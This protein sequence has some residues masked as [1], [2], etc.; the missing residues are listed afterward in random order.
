MKGK[1]VAVLGTFVL[2]SALYGGT[3]HGQST[4]PASPT[5]TATAT[6]GPQAGT[7]VKAMKAFAARKGSARIVGDATI[8]IGT[9]TGTS[10]VVL[11]DSQTRKVSRSVDITSLPDPQGGVPVTDRTETWARGKYSATRDNGGAWSCAKGGNTYALIP[12]PYHYHASGPSTA[13]AINGVPT[14]HVIVVGTTG[15]GQST[16]ETATYDLAQ[17]NDR[18]IQI[19]FS[20]SDPT[21]ISASG[22]GLSITATFTYS[23][24]GEAVRVKL[25]AKC[26]K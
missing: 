3:A 26:A 17:S 1:I 4:P 18:P 13:G 6:P 7:L 23:N 10:S 16:Q 24:W 15:K 9:T 11:D 8:Q 25:P 21:A 14:W 2:T 19:A 20:V 12:V 5:P 22:S